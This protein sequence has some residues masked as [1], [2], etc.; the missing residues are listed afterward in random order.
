[1][2]AG[3]YADHDEDADS[4]CDSTAYEYQHPNITSL[5]HPYRNRDTTDLSMGEFHECRCGCL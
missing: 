5:T 4:Y 2:C 3:E 1:M